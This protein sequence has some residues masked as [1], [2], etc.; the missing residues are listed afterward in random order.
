[1]DS[2]DGCECVVVEWSVEIL[3]WVN[4]G[5]IFYA[6]SEG[7]EVGDIEE[8]EFVQEWFGMCSVVCFC[9][10]SDYFFVDFYEWLYVFLFVVV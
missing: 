4:E 3:F 1:M 10:Y 8:L 6:Y 7:I 9:N 2:A 5:M